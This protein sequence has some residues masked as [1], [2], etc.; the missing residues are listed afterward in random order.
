[1]ALLLISD[2]EDAD[3]WRSRVA[4][5]ASDIDLRVW[6]DVGGASDITMI[7]SDDVMPSGILPS[8]PNLKAIQYLGRI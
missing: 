1:M 5:L 7:A 3:A 2:Y 6:P 8:L 4:E